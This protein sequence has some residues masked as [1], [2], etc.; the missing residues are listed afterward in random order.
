M[1]RE[2][3]EREEKIIKI[4]YYYQ[5]GREGENWMQQD[6]GQNHIHFIGTVPCCYRLMW[7]QLKEV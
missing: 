5:R 3:K 6:E 2:K 4:P 7:T 1:E